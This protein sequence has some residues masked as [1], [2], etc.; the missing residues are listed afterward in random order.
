MR[1]AIIVN[2][3][4]IGILKL[5]VVVPI[6]DPV[7]RLKEWHVELSQTSS[8]GIDKDSVADCFQVK[9]IRQTRFI[10]KLGELSNEEM[11]D[12]KIGLMKVLDL[13]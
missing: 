6:T 5:K 3:D 10:K 11:E 7:G 12:V 4:A 13:L 2:H 1:P 9:S 8:N